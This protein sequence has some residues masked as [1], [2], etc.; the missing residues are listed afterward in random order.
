MSD[1]HTQAHYGPRAGAY[2]ASAVHA[3]G[4][5]LDFIA[6]TLRP[7]PSWSVLDLGCGGGH[8]SYTA[9]PLVARVTA[10]DITAPML[11]AVQ[12]E[13]TAR[14][15]ENITTIQASAEDLPFPAGHFDAVLCRFSAHHWSNWSTGLR[16]ARRV[17][18]PGGTALFIDTTAPTLPRLDSHLQTIELLR[19]PTH[20]RNHTVPEWV[21]ELARAGFSLTGCQSWN[22]RME[23]PVWTARTKTPE[24]MLAAL[25]HLQ[26]TAPEEVK[27]HFAITPDGSF[28]L[29]VVLFALTTA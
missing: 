20:G 4:A 27:T 10:A 13:A 19:D 6:Q 12:A 3:T 5:D 16:E 11:T 9:A 22:L 23:F 7:H 29:D 18:K 24:V 1:P 26:A 28:D 2:V 14:G 17:L 21:A 8:V 15:L 25:R